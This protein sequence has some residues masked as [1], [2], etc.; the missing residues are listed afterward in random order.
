MEIPRMVRGKDN[1]WDANVC[2]NFA[3]AVLNWI[4][5]HV[6]EDD[7]Q[8]TYTISWKQ[9]WQNVELTYAGKTNAFLTESYLKGE[10]RPE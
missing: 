3:N 9:P 1:M 6:T 8:V 5:E 7:P 2:I 10:I 4:R